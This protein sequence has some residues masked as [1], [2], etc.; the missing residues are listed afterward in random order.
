MA[1]SKGRKGAKGDP[2]TGLQK[3][4]RERAKMLGADGLVFAAWHRL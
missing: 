2:V 4:L 1:Q 3:R